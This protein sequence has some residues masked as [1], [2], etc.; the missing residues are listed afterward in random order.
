MSNLAK[1]KKYPHSRVTI[2]Q[3]NTLCCPD[4]GDNWTHQETVIT[5]WR[6]HEDGD[7]LRTTSSNKSINTSRIANKDIEGRRDNIYIKISC[8]QGHLALLHIYQHK[9]QTLFEWK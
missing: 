3:D 8:E 6:F 4:C 1:I 9:G 7:G 5:D 2:L